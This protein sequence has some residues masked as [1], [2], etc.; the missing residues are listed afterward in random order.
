[1]SIDGEYVVAYDPGENVGWAKALMA[2]DHLTGVKH[3]VVRWNEMPAFLHTDDALA[4]KIIY[5]R[6]RARPQN[7]SMNWIQGDEMLSSQVIGMIRMGAWEQGRVAGYYGPDQK[8]VAL[9]SMPDWFKALLADSHAQ[10]DQDAL[11]HLWL[12]FFDNWFTGKEIQHD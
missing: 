8:E 12:Y 5:E 9:A 7:G 11:M 6:W 2:E 1:M 10:H 3:G 4:N